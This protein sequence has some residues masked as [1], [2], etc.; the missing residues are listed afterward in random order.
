[1]RS[2][3]LA[4]LALFCDGGLEGISITIASPNVVTS[5]SPNVATSAA[6]SGLGAGLVTSAVKEAA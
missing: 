5:A 3:S 1:M 4:R 6:S 2:R